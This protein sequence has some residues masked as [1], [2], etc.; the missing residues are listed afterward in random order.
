MRNTSKIS[1]QIS[2]AVYLASIAFFV[3]AL[4]WYNDYKSIKEFLDNFFIYKNY[5]L[6]ILLFI[7]SVII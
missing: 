3:I 1:L 6:I 7:F 5:I 4:F 2:F